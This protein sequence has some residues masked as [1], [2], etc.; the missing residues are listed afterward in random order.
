MHTVTGRTRRFGIAIGAAIAAAFGA[1]LVT[2]QLTSLAQP[3][4]QV[5]ARTVTARGALAESERATIALFEAAAPSVVQVV[6]LAPFG[7][8]YAPIEAGSGFIW[9]NQGHVVTNN[10]VV[11]APEIA[12]R[13]PSGEMI[14][15]RV[16]GRAPQY[17]LAVVRLARPPNAPPLAL[18]SSGDLRVGQ[19]VFAIGNPF[20]LDNTLT[21]G[22]VSALQRR[23]PAPGGREISEVI[24]TDAAI[25]PGNSGGPLLDSAGRVIGVNTAIFS[26]SGANA[27]VGF[28]I[29]IDTVA[30]VAPQ[31]IRDGRAATPGIGVV[32]ATE[33]DAARLGVEGVLI[34]QTAPGAPAARAGLRG[35]NPPTGQL[36]DVII[37]A[38]GRPVRRF[39]DL[40]REIERVGVGGRIPLV[41]QRGQQTVRVTVGV[42]DLGR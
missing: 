1:G 10:H 23:L 21:A 13:M 11:N 18:G 37:E 38:N 28:A 27:G 42:E 14:R 31:L 7:A 17:D 22:I 9:D 8:D 41:L 5:T 32:V 3:A 34:W 24:Q 12:V 20:G 40:A 2:A 4:A 19:A 35:T 33:A 6:G 36:G 30:R 26:P 39:A 16:V 25:N 15:G 29:P